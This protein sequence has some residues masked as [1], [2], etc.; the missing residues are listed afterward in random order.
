M[1]TVNDVI[2]CIEDLS[3]SA[4]YDLKGEKPLFM[5]AVLQYLVEI[6]ENLEGVKISDMLKSPRSRNIGNRFVNL[7]RKTEEIK[8]DP[9]KTWSSKV[10]TDFL[11]VLRSNSEIDEQLSSLNKA[12]LSKVLA[13]YF[14]KLDLDFTALEIPADYKEQ[15]YLFGLKAL[16]EE[17]NKLDSRIRLYDSEI[18]RFKRVNETLG[19]II[20]TLQSEDLHN[21]ASWSDWGTPNKYF[22]YIY[23]SNISRLRASFS[24]CSEDFKRSLFNKYPKAEDLYNKL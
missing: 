12:E 23:E 21:Y 1:T 2:K 5:I 10:N 7:V 9:E 11:D 3:R 4:Y 24:K 6:N 19:N 14:M 16:T 13:R 20:K 17:Y 8:S 22:G 15:L 18:T